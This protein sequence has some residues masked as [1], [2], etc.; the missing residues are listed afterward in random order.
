MVSFTLLALLLFGSRAR[1]ILAIAAMTLGT[2]V[3]YLSGPGLLWLTLASA[4]RARTWPRRFVR[5]V[6]LGALALIIAL[7]VAAPWLEL[8]D[9]LDPLLDETANVGYVNALPDTF[10]LMV[11]DRAPPSLN[12]ARGVERVLVLTL[13]AVYLVWEA[14]RVWL[15]PTRRGIA[16]GLV[17]ACLVY[18][19]VASTSV[20]T[21]Y[22]C[23]P[24][25]V[26]A[27][28]GVRA[29][30]SQLCLAYAAL[31]LPALYLSYYLRDATPGWVFATYAFGPLLL[32]LPILT[33]NGRRFLVRSDVSVGVDNVAVDARGHAD[34]RPARTLAR[35][36]PGG[37]ERGP[38]ALRGLP[39]ADE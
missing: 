1:G 34:A 12:Q 20:Q 3:K 6:V 9:S 28:L 18:I 36:E 39:Q 14:R 37:P 4:A 8:P 15:D 22:F 26:V 25:S 29:R 31:A 38:R 13:F 16:R 27:L 23:L 17:R 5:L 7:V 33:S 24:V 30:L 21:W 32:L 19:L 2:L 35:D 10:L 11:V